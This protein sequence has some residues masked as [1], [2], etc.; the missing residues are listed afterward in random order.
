[1]VEGTP[2]RGRPSAT[3][4]TSNVPTHQRTSNGKSA[5]HPLLL[6]TATHQWRN[7]RPHAKHAPDL[8][9]WTQHTRSSGRWDSEAA[10][11]TP[12]KGTRARTPTWRKYRSPPQEARPRNLRRRQAACPPSALRGNG[13]TAPAKAG[14][15][16]STLSPAPMTKNCPRW[17]ARPHAPPYAT[18]WRRAVDRVTHAGQ[19]AV[20]LHTRGRHGGPAEGV[21]VEPS[22]M[23][24][25]LAADMVRGVLHA[26]RMRRARPQWTIQVY[27]PPRAWPFS[28]WAVLAVM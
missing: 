14:A 28:T 9:R 11:E 5:P 1:M 18:G 3:P 20:A 15:P 22:G 26:S 19:A 24:L 16:N 6:G 8:R 4:T 13:A 21:I 25:V 7:P 23:L 17:D 10:K 27:T 12:H 2:P